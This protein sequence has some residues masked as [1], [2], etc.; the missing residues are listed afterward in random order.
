M[1][2]SI[3]LG[4]GIHVTGSGAAWIPAARTLVVADV[5]VGYELAAQRRG[6]WL[7]PVASGAEVGARLAAV[8]VEI[9]ATRLV[10]AGDLR[11]GTRDVD[12]FERKELAAFGAAVA[13]HVA[14]HVVLGNHDRGGALIDVASSV[15]LRVGN[16]VVVHHPPVVTPKRWTICG[17]LHPRIT[18][19]DETGASARYPCALVGERTLV[20]PAF[21]KWAGGTEAPRLLPELGPGS[22]RVLP[23]AEGSVADVGIVLTSPT[24]E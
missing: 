8:C 5:H 6:G 12:R 2:A 19:R 10:V 14:L 7:P 24:H 15:S 9:G 21:S 3:D 23:I 22:W 20:L 16:V 18:L 13:A 1:R 17:H 11:H 4:G